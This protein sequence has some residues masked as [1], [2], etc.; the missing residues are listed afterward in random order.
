MGPGGQ[1]RQWFLQ[2]HR[3]Y[4]RALKQGLLPIRHYAKPF[5]CFDSLR[6]HSHLLR[7]VR[8]LSH[9]TDSQPEAQEVNGL[10]QDA[11][12]IRRRTT[13]FGSPSLLALN[14]TPTLP[15]PRPL[16]MGGSHMVPWSWLCGW[17]GLPHLFPP[18]QEGRAG[19]SLCRMGEVGKAKPTAVPHA[20]STAPSCHQH[21]LITP[22]F[23]HPLCQSDHCPDS[24]EYSTQEIKGCF[25]GPIP[26]PW[27]SRPLRG[28]LDRTDVPTSISGWEGLIL[29]HLWKQ[30]GSPAG[31]HLTPPV[32]DHPSVSL[33][34]LSFSAFATPSGF[35]C[36]L[37][38]PHFSLSLSLS[39]S[40]PTLPLSV[41]LC[42]SFSLCVSASLCLPP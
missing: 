8:L 25:R 7:L 34:I 33:P 19:V 9:L 5:M 17:R 30:P 18:G 22:T 10:A 31:V 11:Q 1:G 20:P 42:I 13:M 12:L 26:H 24:H 40:P 38:P 28:Q 15:Q 37:A 21:V 4:V 16:R 14:P 2:C 6:P 23:L 41:S 39:Q 36:L 3:A 35:V 27:G 29:C 32:P